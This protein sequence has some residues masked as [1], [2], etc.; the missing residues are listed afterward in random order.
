VAL[1]SSGHYQQLAWEFSACFIEEELRAKMH[2]K[3]GGKHG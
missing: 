1:Y 2:K 3:E